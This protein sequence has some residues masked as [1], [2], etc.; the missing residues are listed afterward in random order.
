LGTGGPRPQQR[1][2]GIAAV[3]QGLDHAAD[4][5]STVRSVNG[6]VTIDNDDRAVAAFDNAT[7]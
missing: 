4:S 2:D 1:V 6:V 7:S 3:H 5:L